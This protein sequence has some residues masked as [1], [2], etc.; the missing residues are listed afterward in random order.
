MSNITLLSKNEIKLFDEPPILPSEVKTIVFSLDPDLKN[1]LD[2]LRTKISKVGFLLQYSYFRA[3][4][5]FF[6]IDKIPKES[7]NYA[8]NLL[9]F[10]Q[11]QINLSNYT[12]KIA[13]QHQ[14]I[15]LKILGFQSFDQSIA[16]WLKKELML[17]INQL[18]EPKQIFYELLEKLHNNNIE[19]PSYYRLADIITGSYLEYENNLL[20][21]IKENLTTEQQLCLNYL[22]DSKNQSNRKELLLNKFK[23]IAQ[24][25]KPKDLKHHV[26]VF[27][28]I[29]KYFDILAPII[30][31]LDLSPNS[32][33]HYAIWVQKAT[34]AQ[35][36]QLADRSKIYLYI[37]SFIQHQLYLRQD[38]FADVTIKCVQ[39]AN[40]A[41]ENKL[42]KQEQKSRKKRKAAIK[43]LRNSRKNYQTLINE[44]KNIIK[45]SVF[46]SKGKINKIEEL[47]N[48]HDEEQSEQAN[49]KEIKVFEETLEKATDDSDY[50]QIVES[51]SVK[52]QNRVAEII[53]MI[54]FDEDEAVKKN[55]FKAIKYFIKKKGIV[56]KKSPIK[57]LTMNERKQIFNDKG[58]IKVSLYKSLLFIHLVNAI[59]SGELSLKYSYKHLSINKYLIDPKIWDKQSSNII[60]QTELTSFADFSKLIFNLK[61]KLNDKYEHINNRIKN[62]KNPYIKINQDLSVVIETP[63][64][65]KTETKYIQD[66]LEQTGFTP[67]YKVLSEINAITLFTKFFKHHSFKNIKYTPTAELF[68]AGILGLRSNI[69]IHRMHQISVGI[70]KNSLINTVK[71]YFNKGSLLNANDSILQLINQI[72]L[73][74]IFIED[75][76]VLHGSSDG[77]K[78]AVGAESILANFSFKYFGKEKG[79]SVYTFIDERQILFYSLVMS[80][81]EREASYV[82]DGLLNNTV[83]NIKIHSTDTHGYTEII[84]AITYLLGIMFAPRIKKVGK[85]WL[86]SFLSK[87]IHEERG[88]LIS[89]NRSINIKLIEENWQDILRFIA[90]IKLKQVT[91]STLLKR[92]NSYARANPL[93]K[94]LKEFGRIIKSYYILTYFDDVRLR[95]RVEKQLNKGELANKFSH[96][97]FYANDQKFKQGDPDNQEIAILCKSLIQNAVILWNYLYLSQLL[98]TCVDFEERKEMIFLIKQSSVI[99]WLHINFY[100]Q[101]VFKKYRPAVDNLFDMKK[102]LSLKI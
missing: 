75:P 36:N 94:A 61:Q 59:K 95:Q 86:Y 98:A 16:T 79:M 92:L 102:I 34:I 26:Q 67:I 31:L 19:I 37:I 46:T 51:L 81:S 99:T 74:K 28:E 27:L 23:N 35:L 65:E 18:I 2:Q 84:F 50:F 88:D 55:L 97:V 7:V 71:W 60:K 29:K 40:N 87:K 101:F 68:I 80:S 21:I 96:A 44:I 43:Y 54:I 9:N 48:K 90:T 72:S 78:V 52:L 4:K 83:S 56:N 24:T 63:P 77:M 33:Q 76:E 11:E 53:Q 8:I 38:F 93:Y 85:Q 12:S 82:I 70:K 73:P 10:N 64:T 69:G 100:G 32:C 47:I 62:N 3:C 89:P 30:K 57:F 41:T 45:S 20:F 66:L 13:T 22:V 25:T 42:N 91:A 58:S 15:I 14:V 49:N 17:K 6:L 1:Q 5:K 39:A